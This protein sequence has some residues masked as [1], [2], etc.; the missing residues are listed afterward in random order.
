RSM[1]EAQPY[2]RALESGG[3]L[4]SAYQRFDFLSQWQRHIGTKEGVTPAIVVGFDRA[5]APLVVLPFG[6]QPWAALKIAEF[7]GGKHVNFNLGLW[8]RDFINS[9]DRETI[10][11]LFAALDADALVLHNQ[12]VRWQGTANPLTQWP[13]TAAPSF[14]H[15][16]ALKR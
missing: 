15:K 10:A 3:A 8:R 14:G 6:T 1:D 7:L 16:G 13:H 11:R 5:G 4:M 12:P 9:V 2:W